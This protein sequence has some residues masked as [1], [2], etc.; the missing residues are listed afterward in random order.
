M[1]IVL[2]WPMRSSVPADAAPRTAAAV[3][4]AAAVVATLNRPLLDEFMFP[5]DVGNCAS[6]RHL[7]RMDEPLRAKNSAGHEARPIEGHS[8]PEIR[9]RISR[10]ACPAAASAS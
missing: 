2:S 7:F 10:G 5:P 3:I 9:L 4:S 8:V 1:R 6:R